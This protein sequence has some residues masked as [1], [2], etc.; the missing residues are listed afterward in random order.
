MKNPI[1]QSNFSISAG[2]MTRCLKISKADV[3]YNIFIIVFLLMPGLQCLRQCVSIT[4]HITLMLVDSTVKQ[5]HLA[6][7]GWHCWS[8]QF[9]WRWLLVRKG[10]LGRARASWLV[11]S[12]FFAIGSSLVLVLRCAPFWCWLLGS[13]LVG[14]LV[15]GY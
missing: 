2:K 12:F 4:S 11:V 10:A 13:V 6:R 5:S 3:F 8:V 7:L 1:L 15:L 14:P 9:R